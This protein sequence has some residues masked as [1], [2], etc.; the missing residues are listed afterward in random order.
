[1]TV[2]RIRTLLLKF[3]APAALA[4]VLA[5]SGGCDWTRTQYPQ[6]SLTPTSD[7]ARD[8]DAILNQ[9][10]FWVVV[11]FVL[12]QGMIIVTVLRFRARPGAPDPKPVHGNTALE[13]AWTIAP[14][15]I[16]ALVAVP[17]VQTI[18]RTQAPAA[19]DAIQVKVIGHQWW[20]EFQ[21]PDLGITTASELHVPVGKTVNVAI[22]T[23]DV[24]HSFWFPAIGGKRD[25]I[26]SHTNYM[27]FKPD[28]LGVFMGQCAELCG[29]SHANMRMRL[30]VDTPEQF[31]AWVAHQKEPASDPDSVTNAAAWQGRKV[32]GD[33][34]CFTCHTVNGVEN[35]VGIV[36]PN[37]T[38]VGSRTA[39][40]GSI[41]PNDAEHLAKWISNAPAAKP[42]S[43]MPNLGL[44]DEQVKAL[45]AYLQSLK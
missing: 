31:E 1:M 21:Y 20:W 22:E 4:V 7:Y 18:Y 17:T 3:A 38:H 28:S 8:I 13:I 29:T 41:Y 19:K 34:I 15:I 40:A 33:Q 10:V 42:G 43:L 11:I 25:A 45:V 30:F 6:T 9:Q 44:N 24:L 32:W 2:R 39:I 35:A 14:A 26:P 37:L 5:A 16:L 12:V 27:W 23:A 36:G